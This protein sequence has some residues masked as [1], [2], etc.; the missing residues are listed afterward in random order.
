MRRRRADV[1]GA[2]AEPVVEADTNGQERTETL[3]RELV[4]CVRQQ[5]GG[6]AAGD[7]AVILDR[8]VDGVRCLLVQVPEQQPV[9]LSPREKEI[10][11]MVAEGYPNKT[12]AGVLDISSWT[13]GTHLRRVF[14]K[15][16]VGSRAAMV[17]RL[18][19][20]RGLKDSGGTT[21]RETAA[22]DAKSPVASDRRRTGT[23]DR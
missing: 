6:P 1:A 22:G 8:E 14:L 5:A 15:L 11:R 23:N 19:E 10:V 21:V 20:A 18:F 3:L 17:A 16:G 12:I 9:Q 7:P 13:V 4:A 2:D